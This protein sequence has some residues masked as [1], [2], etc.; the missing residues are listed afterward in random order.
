ME[1]SVIN[2]VPLGLIA[3]TAGW[4]HLHTEAQSRFIGLFE[5]V[6]K[7]E[8]G[9]IRSKSS[10]L[11]YPHLCLFGNNEEM[12]ISLEYRGNEGDVPAVTSLSLRARH[13]DAFSILPRPP[14][15]YFLF[16]NQPHEVDFGP[17]RFRNRYLVSGDESLVKALFEALPQEALNQMMRLGKMTVSA[18]NGRFDVEL[19]HW[20]KTPDQMVRAV[21]FCRQFYGAYK[22]VTT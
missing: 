19:H 10:L 5:A 4:V 20:T 12:L 7:Q 18:R 11:A 8:D 17:E 9:E 1:I 21:A 3:L 14:A 2:F 16:R 13:G 22:A 15:T 6:L